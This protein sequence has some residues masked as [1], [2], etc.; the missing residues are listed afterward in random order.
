M[1]KLWL[2]DDFNFSILVSEALFVVLMTS[3]EV[4]VV[5]VLD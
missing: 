1:N 2:N 5:P 3:H 4:K